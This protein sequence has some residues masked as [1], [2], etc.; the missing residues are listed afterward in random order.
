MNDTVTNFDLFITNEADHVRVRVAGQPTIDQMLSLIHLLGVDSG[1]WE[2]DV[3]L[4]DLCSVQTQFTPQ[5]QFQLGQETALSL[6]HMRRIASLVP[7]ERITRISEKAAQRDA[8]NL[9]VFSD[10]PTALAWL[11]A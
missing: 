2:H 5:E 10:E 7:A 6:A 3:L 8:T 9:R 4:V 1:H 11:R